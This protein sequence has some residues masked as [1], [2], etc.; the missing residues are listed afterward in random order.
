MAKKIYIYIGPNEL[1]TKIY[2]TDE[3]VVHF[4][5]TVPNPDATVADWA[6]YDGGMDYRYASGAENLTSS[7]TIS[8]YTTNIGIGVYLLEVSDYTSQKAY[9]CE[10]ELSY[11]VRPSYFDWTIPKES[12]SP[13]R[14]SADEWNAFLD[15]VNAVRVMCGLTESDFERATSGNLADRNVVTESEV[16]AGVVANTSL[17]SYDIL[18]QA[19]DAI[20]G[21]DDGSVIGIGISNEYADLI[22][23]QKSDKLSAD[24]F[25]NLRDAVNSVL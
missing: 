17:I 8:F 2:I 3:G 14:V 7:K 11:D 18:R 24:F 20:C 13:V 5:C 21:K 25:N 4:R 22:D 1:D 23:I 6:I 16:N 9:R 12:G 19:V 15:H 10:F